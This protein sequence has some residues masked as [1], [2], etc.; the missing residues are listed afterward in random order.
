MD[1]EKQRERL[2]QPPARHL[3]PRFNFIPKSTPSFLSQAV[4]ADEEWGQW[5][6]HKSSS[7][8]LL[9][10]HTCPC[11]SVGP[12]HGSQ[13]LSEEPVPAWDLHAVLS[14]NICLLQPGPIHRLQRNS[15]FYC[16]LFHGVQEIPA[17]TVVSS[18]PS[19]GCRG[20]SSPGKSMLW[21]R[22]TSFPLFFPD[23]GVHRTVSHTFCSFI[24]CLCDMF[25]PF[26]KHILPEVVPLWLKGALCPAA[27]LLELAVPLLA[28]PAALSPPQP[29]PVNSRH[30]GRLYL[31]KFSWI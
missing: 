29:W 13:F 25:F 20:I 22:G 5:L 1:D 19:M 11:S 27:D 14:G 17:V 30:A 16:S 2:N 18:K 26:L 21:P 6:V 10:P 23:L 12:P 8:L 31:P 15:C 9:P 24:L 4:Q 7:L 3:F 28:I